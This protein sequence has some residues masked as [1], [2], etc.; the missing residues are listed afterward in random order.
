MSKRR[1]GGFAYTLAFFIIVVSGL[2]TFFYPLLVREFPDRTAPIER[3]RRVYNGPA[4]DV[5][6]EGRDGFS[7]DGEVI[8]RRLEAEPQSY[9]FVPAADL[10]Y[11]VSAVHGFGSDV[12]LE[13]YDVDSG[14]LLDTNLNY[15]A[16]T[17][18]A[19]DM[20]S[21]MGEEPDREHAVGF[22][23]SLVSSNL[24]ELRISAMNP[25]TIHDDV[26]I[27]VSVDTKEIPIQVIWGY[28]TGAVIVLMFALLMLRYFLFLRPERKGN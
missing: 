8:T 18:R 9:Y 28:F 23:T 2:A 21:D 12:R 17:G 3:F 19:A 16:Y 25:G 5:L 7:R 14:A 15:P 20:Y 4:F 26:D 6:P 1:G 22:T 10:P 11:S 27:R 13:L 24:Y